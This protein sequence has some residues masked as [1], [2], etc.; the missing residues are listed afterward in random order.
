VTQIDAAPDPTQITLRLDDLS[1]AIRHVEVRGTVE[2]ETSIS[3]TTTAGTSV[4]AGLDLIG[5]PT[6]SVALKSDASANNQIRTKALG[7]T[8]TSIDFGHL[9]TALAGLLDVLGSPRIWLL[10]DEWSEIPLD[11]QPLLADLLRRTVLPQQ[12]VVVKIAA[13]EH[14]SR[15]AQPLETGGFV[16]IEIGADVTADINL[17][18][19]VVYDVDQRRATEFFRNLLFKH[20]VVSEKADSISTADMLLSAVF[21]Q[22]TAF[23]EFV[24][25][26]EG[27]P[28]DALNLAA[29]VARIAY[30]RQISVADVRKAAREWY[31]QDK[32]AVTK[33]APALA[34]LLSYIVGEVIENRRTRAFLF[35][36]GLNAPQVD[37]LY[38]ARLLHLLKKSIASNDEPGR[39]YDVFKIDYGCYVDLIS[40]TKAPLGL[41]A[42][43]DGSYVDV[44]PDDYR[45]IRRAILRPEDLPT[46]V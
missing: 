1:D 18:D 5:K 6:A 37:Q 28:R 2:R 42:G 11:L 13:I 15:F 10:I 16:G 33:N 43:D 29:M 35:P 7:V 12:R 25:A 3:Q 19:F 36:S 4:Q 21:T 23:Q 27:V 30:G 32:M 26:I 17:D 9:Q 20:Y 14:R 46:V 40:T 31:Q 45:S 22:S 39:R 44:P 41:L 38:D 24:R 8:Q 34:E